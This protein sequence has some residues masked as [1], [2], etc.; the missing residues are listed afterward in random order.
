MFG[1]RINFL[2]SFLL[3]VFYEKFQ[4]FICRSCQK[5]HYESKICWGWGILGKENIMHQSWTCSS[6]YEKV[7]TLLCWQVKTYQMLCKIQKNI[8]NSQMCWNGGIEGYI[9]CHQNERK[10]K[11]LFTYSATWWKTPWEISET[12]TFVFLSLLIHSN[13]C[14]LWGG[15]CSI[16]LRII[17]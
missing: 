16:E 5:P 9:S 6:V 11:K 8:P 10:K 14:T 2:G 3:D 1:N 12:R 4:L 7:Y 17:L 15:G 13:F